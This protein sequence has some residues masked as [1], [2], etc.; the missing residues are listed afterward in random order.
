MNFEDFGIFGFDV[1]F[2][3]DVNATSQK[4]DFAKM[5]GYGA[6]FA[7]IKAGQYT[8]ADEDFGDNWKNCKE[9]GLPRSSYWF[10]DKD[11]SGQAQARRYWNLMRYDQPEGMLF[12]DYESGSWTDWRQ[13]YNFLKELQNLSGYSSDRIGIYTGYYYWTDHSPLTT[14]SLNWFKQFPL[15]IAAYSVSPAFVR[16]PKPWTECLLWQDGTPPVGWLAGAESKEID[17]NRFNGEPDKFERYMGGVPVTPP[18]GGDVIHYYA[19][20]KTGYTSNVRNGAGLSY[21]TKTQLTGPLTVSIVSEKTT[22][23]GYDWYQIESPTTGWIALTTSYTNFRSATPTPPTG[24]M[25]VTAEMPDG[26]I[27]KG[28]LSKQ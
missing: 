1:S 10:C 8:Y 16:V 13:L 7:V 15:W 27:W 26:T 28:E 11:D 2:Y 12:A 14:L 21:S 6:S 23:D 9:A 19:D 24:T 5:R 3:Q 4:I 20:L 17:H 22:V 25:K 18:P